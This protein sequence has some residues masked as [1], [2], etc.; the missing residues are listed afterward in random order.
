MVH[1]GPRAASLTVLR[2]LFVVFFK[3]SRESV[4]LSSEFFLASR[5]RYLCRRHLLASD[6]IRKD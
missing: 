1:L 4:N 2:A 3:I 5:V 6:L